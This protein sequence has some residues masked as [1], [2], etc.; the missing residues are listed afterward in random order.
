MIARWERSIERLDLLDR[1]PIKSGTY[2]RQNGALPTKE[3]NI[4]RMLG[5]LLSGKDACREESCELTV[6]HRKYV[7]YA[8]KSK[9]FNQRVPTATLTLIKKL[10]PVFDSSADSRFR[11][12]LEGVKGNQFTHG[13]SNVIHIHALAPPPWHEMNRTMHSGRNESTSLY[14]QS[15]PKPTLGG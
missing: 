15:R 3:R 12:W 7:F 4:V 9:Y 11:A 6:S 8:D 2:W 5:R 10:S 14:F 13:S 1:H